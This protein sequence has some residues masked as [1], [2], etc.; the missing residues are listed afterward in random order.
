MTP[1][2]RMLQSAAGTLQAISETAPGERGR[3]AAAGALVLRAVELALTAEEGSGFVLARARTEVDAL[4]GSRDKS[5]LQRLLVQLDDADSPVDEALLAESL[6]DYAFELETTSRLPEADA[7]LALALSLAPQDA[8]IPL[9][10]GRVARKM[11]DGERALALYRSAQ[12]LDRE[13]GRIARLARVGEAVVS[14]DPERMLGRA[15]REA[16]LAGDMEAAAVGLEERARVRRAAGRRMAAARDL[17]VA[18][19]RFADLVDRAR[20]AHEL[21]DIFVAAGD[22]LAAREAVLL[23]LALGDSS[24]RDHARSRLHTI[25]RELGDQVGM[26]RWRAF[27]RPSLVS[28]SARARVPQAESTAPRL[29]R[30]RETVAESSFACASA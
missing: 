30:W 5:Q 11:V 25:S 2:S 3:R 24:Q 8:T 10:A 27:E 12:A 16:V 22:G 23:A 14:A 13:N 18:T 6:V 9:H 20:V 21:A 29:A 7:A 4:P 1:I 26:R 28:L 19:A 17:C 15:I